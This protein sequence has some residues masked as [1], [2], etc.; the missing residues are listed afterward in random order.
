VIIRFILQIC[1]FRKSSRTG[2]TRIFIPYRDRA[3]RARIGLRFIR[4]SGYNALIGQKPALI[5]GSE[6]SFYAE[7]VRPLIAAFLRPVFF[8]NVLADA[9]SKRTRL[10][11]LQA[12][13]LERT[14][15]QDFILGPGNGYHTHDEV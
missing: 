11:E 14:Y 15:A 3:I 4:F 9:G 5:Q 8:R 6:E 12:D 7:E 10:Q 13:F 2:K 1:F